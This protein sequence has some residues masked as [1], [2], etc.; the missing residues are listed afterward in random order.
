MREN[1]VWRNVRHS[2]PKINIGII[3]CIVQQL[4]DM[5]RNRRENDHIYSVVHGHLQQSILN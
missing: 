2:Y 4:K 5:I 3:K 1:I